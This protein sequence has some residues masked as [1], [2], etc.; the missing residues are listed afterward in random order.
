MGFEQNKKTGGYRKIR[1]Y[2]IIENVFIVLAF[3]LFAVGVYHY[4]VFGF[5]SWAPYAYMFLGLVLFSVGISIAIKMTRAFT[6][7]DLPVY[8]NIMT[9][10]DIDP[11]TGLLYYDEFIKKAESQLDMALTDSFFCSFQIEGAEHLRHF[12]GYQ[13]A[14]DTMAEV[15]DV[16]KTFQRKMSEQ[17]CT[18]GCKSGHEIVMLVHEVEYK[19]MFE[20]LEQLMAEVNGIL[21]GLETAEPLNCFCAF[22][23]YPQHASTLSE[24]VKNTNFAI[25]EAVTFRKSEP[26]MFSRDSF[27]RQETEY[28]KDNKLRQILDNN[29]LQYNFQPI[30]SAKTGKIYAYEA[31]MRTNKEMGFTPTDVLE[32]AERQDRLYDVEHYT[33][34]NVIRIMS[35]N[36]SYFEN[37]KLF[38]N[39]IPTVIIKENEFDN[40]LSM[41]GNVMGALVIE[42]TENGMQSEESCETVH[43]YMKK[44][45]CEL[46]LDDYGTGYSNASTLLNNSPQYLKIDHSMI[47]GIDTDSKKQHLVASYVSFANSHNMQILAEGVENSEEL[48]MVIQL[49]CHLIQGFYTCKPQNVIIDAIDEQIENE[50]LDLNLQFVKLSDEKKEYDTVNYDNVSVVNLA[51]DFYSQ[52]NVKDTTTRIVGDKDR[53]VA[54]NIKVADGLTGVLAIRDVNIRGKDSPSIVLGENCNLV[55]CIEGDNTLSYEGIMVPESSHLTIQGSGNLSVH[56]DHIGGVG[57]GTSEENKPYGRIKF[58]QNGTVSITNNGDTVVGIGGYTS[59]ENS[60]LIFEHGN[61]EVI[62]NGAR[63]VGIG[64]IS[65]YTKL[66]L[67]RSVIAISSSG[68]DCVGIGTFV[69]EVNIRSIADIELDVSGSNSVGIGCLKECG[70]NIEIN[71]GR[72]SVLLHCMNGTAIGS[73]NGHINTTICGE[74]IFVYVEG[75]DVCGI[76]NFRGDGFT[77]IRT[78]VVKVSLLAANPVALGG[79]KGKLEITGGNILADLSN[80]PQPVNAFNVP[81]YPKCFDSQVV[82]CKKI[83][84]EEGAYQY[85]AKPTELFDHVYIYVPKYY[86]EIDIPL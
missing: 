23:A 40:L 13:K 24:L 53:E 56:V 58:D 65:G 41:Y 51:L 34:Y 54:M 72:V 80:S 14:A 8:S 71:E 73:F 11:E 3:L 50:I 38:I 4:I 10:E 36:A 67:N 66:I 30:V 37:R 29:L 48:A 86:N 19:D 12:V 26:H 20:Y 77:V 18:V 69:G 5:R 84:T 39:S 16:F 44:S 21:A 31:L 35:E 62:C 45:G 68:A 75:S 17:Y 22:S 43:N 55:L 42:I 79:L 61:I 9:S 32:L 15:G 33:F 64:S 1:Y 82:Y 60:E 7:N 74:E 49:G 6:R 76:G 78:G 70:G 85:R 47:T 25:Y 57:I 83:A 52:I 46:A 2:L 81:V 59:N 63:S 28:L 27:N